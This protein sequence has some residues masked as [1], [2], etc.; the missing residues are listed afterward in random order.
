MRIGAFVLYGRICI[1]LSSMLRLKTA[2]NA[3][4]DTILGQTVYCRSAEM[5]RGSTGAVQRPGRSWE[6]K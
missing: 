3:E 2:L 6:V 5:L 1:L 4:Q